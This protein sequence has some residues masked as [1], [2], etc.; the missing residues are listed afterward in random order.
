MEEFDGK[1]WMRHCHQANKGAAE[2][3]NGN[4]HADFGLVN[5]FIGILPMY[6]I[7]HSD[8]IYSSCEKMV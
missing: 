6:G 2:R 4:L 3:L 1:D 8:F 5:G 7:F